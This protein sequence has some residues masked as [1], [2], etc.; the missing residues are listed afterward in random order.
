M[1]FFGTRTPSSVQPL[2]REAALAA[3]GVVQATFGPPE[4]SFHYDGWALGVRLRPFL[5][6]PSDWPT[7]PTPTPE[8]TAARRWR[9]PLGS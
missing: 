5:S 6:I 4:P 1:G 8:M 2:E 7:P 3:L 9:L